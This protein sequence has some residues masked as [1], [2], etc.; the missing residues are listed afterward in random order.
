MAELT[1]AQGEP[2]QAARW[3]MRARS[4]DPLDQRA[5]RLFITALDAGGHR[6]G[7]AEA[8]KELQAALS[9]HSLAP[10]RETARLLIRFAQ[11]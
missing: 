11:N 8:A 2:E 10:D 6:S 9:A 1:S 3:A 5:A 7:A 4:L